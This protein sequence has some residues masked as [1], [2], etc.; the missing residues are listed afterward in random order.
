MCCN[1]RA[2]IN[3]QL[4]WGSPWEPVCKNMECE[5]CGVVGDFINTA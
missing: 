2:K 3:I 5:K 4:T 1:C